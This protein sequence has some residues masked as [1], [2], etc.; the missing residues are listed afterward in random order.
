M[1]D[2]NSILQRLREN[3][4]FSSPA[5]PLPWNN[6]NPD[7]LNLNRETSDEIEQLIRRKRLKP[8][9]PLGGLILGEAGSGKTHML[10][11]ILRKL[12]SNAQ[13]AV[14]VAV[15][16]FTDPYS[17]T[18]HILSEI[19]NSLRLIHSNQHSQFDMITSEF[20]NAYRERRQND[21][22][23]NIENLDP[24]V[25]IKKDIPRLNRNFLKCLL[26][27]MSASDE[28]MKMDII[29]WLCFELDDEDSL[30]LGLPLRDIDSM[31]S[32]KR[33]QEAENILISLGL[34]LA[35][36]KVP[37]IICFDQLDGMKDKENYRELITAWGNIISLLMNDLSGILPLCFMKA[38][39]WND[40][41]LPIL[42][43]AV[44]QRIK[45]NRMIMKE[46]SIKQA[47]QLIHDRITAVFREDAEETY[48]WLISKISI[49]KGLSPRDVIEL[50]NRAIT[51]PGTTIN[52][53]DEINKT[54]MGVFGDEYKKV[55][56]VPVAWPP[57][58]NQ[59]A[60]A[61]EVWLDS[62]GGFN[63]IKN[64]WKYIKVLELHGDRR[65]AFVII[66]PKTHFTAAA[67][68]QEAMKF[69]K[70]YPGS[71]CC[72]VLEEKSH[73]KTWK[74]F[75]ERLKE[76]EQAGGFVT[77][78]DKESRISWYALAALINRIDNGDVN[79]YTSST[80]R[81]AT[82]ND[83]K[84]FVRTLKLIDTESIKPSEL[85]TNSPTIEKNEVN[86]VNVNDNVNNYDD[87]LV[88][89]TLKNIISASPMKIVTVDKAAD[90]LSQR[91]IKLG[92]NDVIS[93]IK[94]NSHLFKT[95]TSKNKDTLVT[96]SSEAAD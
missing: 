96:L 30:N 28:G 42:D 78:L 41:F 91:G 67:G 65:F 17:V 46:C 39:T 53:T 72:Y 11:R 54:I 2:N 18:Q 95:F 32:A 50:A 4:P 76:F 10:T 92:R 89:D 47:Q 87:A 43:E 61:L 69:M 57:N 80:H 12:R 36:A 22:F 74:R 16:A 70:E 15:R 14:F 19:F 83:I 68:V 21:G 24:R 56:A 38:Q 25:Y 60:F 81:T 5:S 75:F 59:L 86:E 55:Q 37:M 66:T 23:E 52:T 82:R 45:N 49:T 7:L 35:Y 33:E 58:A 44:A 13:L 73:K 71:F 29:D 1:S 9:E 20:M 93:I 6:T 77:R 40:V 8:A 3:N 64:T 94:N 48:N 27:Y 90:I 79:I 85:P 63:I 88:K 26:S 34:V 51:N 62:I 84:D 31:T